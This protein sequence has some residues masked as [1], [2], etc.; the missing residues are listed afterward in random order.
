MAQFTLTLGRFFGQNVAGKCLIATDF[1][2][3]GL[4]EAFGGSTVCL[5]LGH[6]FFSLA[7][8]KSATA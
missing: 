4:A 3:S 5:N 8:Y 7:F 1:A 2:S 6:L